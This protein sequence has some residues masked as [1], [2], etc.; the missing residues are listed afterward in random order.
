MRP[1][2]RALTAVTGAVGLALAAACG[3]SAGSQPGTGGSATAS[4][5]AAPPLPVVTSTNVWAD[6][7]RQIGGDR[8]SVRALITEPSQDPHSFQPS[9]RD[10]LAVSRAAVIIQNGG[11]Y[12]DVMSMMVDAVDSTATVVTAVAAAQAVLAQGPAGTRETGPTGEAAHDPAADESSGE[13]N[14]HIWYDLDAVS[15]VAARI[16]D[17]FASLDPD[18]ASQF[19]RNLHD[20]QA[21]LAPLR[22]AIE[23]IRQR[24]RGAP[25]AITEP[26]PVYLVEAAGLTNVTPPEFSEA[27]EEGI[28][29]TPSVLSDT[30]A[31]FTRQKVKVLLYNEQSTSPQSDQVLAAAKDNGVPVVPVTETLP[32][33]QHYAGWMRGTIDTLARALDR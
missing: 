1:A 16:A 27:L 13:T 18:A 24:H 9:G 23:Q 11:G 4:A 2:L 26:L 25:V 15:A 19:Q 32:A 33:G 5:H 3:A 8:V 22:R 21:G 12:D 6:V 29:V 30:V 7:A 10:E 31:L 14:E 28:D 17:A 20:F